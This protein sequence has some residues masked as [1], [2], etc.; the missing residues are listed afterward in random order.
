VLASFRERYEKVIASHPDAKK[1]V[2]LVQASVVQRG[3]LV[4]NPSKVNGSGA[5]RKQQ[6]ELKQTGTNSESF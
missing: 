5:K 2:G 1:D 4:Q 6:T 3:Q